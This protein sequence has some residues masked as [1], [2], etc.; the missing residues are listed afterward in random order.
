[1]SL[2]IKTPLR[3]KALFA[4]VALS[5]KSVDAISDQ[6]AKAGLTDEATDEEIDTKLNERNAL[7]SFEDQKKFDDYQVGKA[8]KEAADK[9][10]KRLADLAAGKTEEVEIPNDVPE[11]MK[12][13]MATQLAQTKALQ[14][15]LAAISGEKVTNT[16]REQYAKV[17]EGKSP[18][19]IAAE[20]KKFDRMNFKD[21]EDFTTVLTDFTQ[22]VA[23]SDLG[24][25]RP[26]GGFGGAAAATGSKKV[27][28]SVT[29]FIAKQ[30]AV[31]KT[32]VSSE[33]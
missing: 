4:G 15:Q 30:E 6:L 19:F 1:M 33:N 29:A 17:L 20:L 16:R 31:R 12:T 3:L 23:N 13:F 26:A 27:D 2:K 18:E 10:A 5:K 25:E 22:E 28:P 8:T 14:D 11:Y 21:D 7:F 24:N 32:A 9:E